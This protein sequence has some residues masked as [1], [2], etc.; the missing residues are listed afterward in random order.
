MNELH[1]FNGEY[2]EVQCETISQLVVEIYVKRFGLI[3]GVNM[4]YQSDGEIS[5]IKVYPLHVVVDYKADQGQR[6][7]GLK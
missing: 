4:D 5:I 1:I 2:I 6:L 3:L 7:I